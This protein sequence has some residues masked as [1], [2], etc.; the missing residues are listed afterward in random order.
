MWKGEAMTCSRVQEILPDYAV[1]LLDR[2]LQAAVDAHLAICAGCRRELEAQERALELVTTLGGRTPAAGLFHAVRNEIESG[3]AR[4]ER[5]GWLAWFNFLPVRVAATGLAMASVALALLAPIGGPLLP[6]VPDLHPGP[7]V[8]GGQVARGP[9]AH[10]IRQHARSAADGPL[11][12]RVA[13]EA[14][15]QLAESEEDRER[16]ELSQPRREGVRPRSD[17]R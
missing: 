3:R 13:W 7:R 9:L 16:R 14:M 6:P 11:A 17:A 1:E 10:S 5:P 15:A 12:D 4:Q 8:Q 2:R